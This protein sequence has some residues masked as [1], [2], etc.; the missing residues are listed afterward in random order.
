[1]AQVRGRVIERIDGDRAWTIID[2]LSIKYLGQRYPL[3]EDRVV[4]LIQIEHAWGNEF[5]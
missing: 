5:G 4:L 2:R 3:R 1:M